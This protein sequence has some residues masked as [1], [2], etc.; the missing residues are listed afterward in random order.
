[1]LKELTLPPID[2]AAEREE[3]KRRE[4]RQMLCRCLQRIG[5]GVVIGMIGGAFVALVAAAIV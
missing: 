5:E 1:M 4:R 2:W 3:R